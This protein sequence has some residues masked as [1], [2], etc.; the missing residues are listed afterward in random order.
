VTLADIADNCSVLQPGQRHDPWKSTLL[1]GSGERITANN[2]Q[3]Q[4]PEIIK[5]SRRYPIP[6][7]G[8]DALDPERSPLPLL[9]YP[10]ISPH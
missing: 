2:S 7:P 6:D 1:G 9:Q 3:P 8:I 10:S 4:Q 5:N